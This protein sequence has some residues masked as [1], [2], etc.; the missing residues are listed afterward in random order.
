MRVKLVVVLMATCIGLT[1]CGNG[2]PL[3]VAGGID[4][5]THRTIYSYPFGRAVIAVRKDVLTGRSSVDAVGRGLSFPMDITAPSVSQVVDLD[6][7]RERVAVITGPTFDCPTKVYLSD[8]V[9]FGAGHAQL[10]VLPVPGCQPYTVS[11]YN[12]QGLLFSDASGTPAILYGQGGFHPVTE[13]PRVAEVRRPVQVYAT[14]PT[15]SVDTTR[16]GHLSSVGL[17][18]AEG[19][20]GEQGAISPSSVDL[21]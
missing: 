21:N 1:S 7:E 5:A 12:D 11:P 6:A 3:T 17:P 2:E 16:Y 15:P 20:I 4:Y 19:S 10:T 9:A 14:R 13:R 18:S 8:T